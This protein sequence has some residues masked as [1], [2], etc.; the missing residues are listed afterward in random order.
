[1]EFQV[2]TVIVSVVDLTCRLARPAKDEEIK[3]AMKEAS[4][5]PMKGIVAYT[6]DDVVSTDINGKP[7]TCVFD[8]KAGIALNDHFVKLMA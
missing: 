8:A 3:T 7:C 6:E 4:G 5:G 1:M 2:P